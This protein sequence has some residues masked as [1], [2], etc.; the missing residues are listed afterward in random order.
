MAITRE[1]RIFIDKYIQTMDYS[2]SAREMGVSAK[3]APTAGLD[4]IRNPEIQEAIRI[5]RDELTQALNAVPITKEQI[6][7]IMMFQYQQANQ[8]NKTKEAVE[9]LSKIAEANGIDMDTIQAE[10][11]NLIINNLDENK[12]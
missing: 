1:H 4:L 6:L 8:Q 10:P 9:I 11:V 5:R 7:A 2:L 3:E 12:I